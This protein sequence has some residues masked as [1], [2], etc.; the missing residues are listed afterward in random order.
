MHFIHIITTLVCLLCSLAYSKTLPTPYGELYHLKD[1]IDHF[2]E[3]HFDDHEVGL[4]YDMLELFSE[5][6]EVFSFE[7]REENDDDGQYYDVIV[8]VLNSLNSSGIIWTLLDAVADHPDRVNYIANLTSSLLKGRNITINVADIILSGSNP[9]IQQNVNLSAIS[10]AIQE[11]GLVTSLMD[12]ILLDENFRPKLVDLIY[13]VVLSQKNVLLYIFA[14][15]LQKRDSMLYDDLITEI[16]KRA[17][18]AASNDEFAGTMQSFLTNGLATI[19][20]SQ[21]FG[22]FTGS[23]LNALNDTGFAVYFIKRF[24]STDSYMNMTSKLISAVTSSGAIHISFSGLNISELVTS[25]IEDPTI[26]TKLI[27]SLLGGD[28]N[29]LIGFFGKYSGA[30]QQILRDLEKKGLFAEL[31]S[32]I[33]GD[34]SATTSI[35]LAPGATSNANRVIAS[36]TLAQSTRSSSTSAKSTGTTSKDQQNDASSLLSSMTILR[37]IFYTQIVVVIAFFI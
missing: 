20:G 30:I 27:G 8:S 33:F 26:I 28:P 6:G 37:S 14:G 25:A 19:L 1:E 21:A 23:L 24:I 4:Y 32:Y 16:L 5:D 18:D 11:S 34:E 17:D 36:T 2:V 29:S 10:A 7:K 3:T 31:N 9:I 13:N 35:T 12:G 15:V 22:Q